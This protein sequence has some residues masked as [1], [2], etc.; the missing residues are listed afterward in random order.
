MENINC[1]I[2]KTDKIHRIILGSLLLL[3]AIFDMGKGFML[4]LGAIVLV[5]GILGKCGI[6]YL[7]AKYEQLK[8]K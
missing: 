6:P 7:I 3:G 5:E 4:T 1:N 8:N 2:D